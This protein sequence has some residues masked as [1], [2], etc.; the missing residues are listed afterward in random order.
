MRALL[1][2]LARFIRHA[3]GLAAA[4]ETDALTRQVA[5]AAKRLRRLDTV[6]ARLDEIKGQNH[7]LRTE[8]SHLRK[9]LE[10][11]PTR[12]DVRDVGQC[13][14]VLFSISED[15]CADA[16]VLASV[17]LLTFFKQSH[18]HVPGTMEDAH[19]IDPYPEPRFGAA[20]FS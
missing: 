2:R 3:G 19:T 6:E 9:L 13:V 11:L 7:E 16:A 4:E 8:V 1:G 17:A 20:R 12:R 5:A 10:A 14:R 18:R 15:R